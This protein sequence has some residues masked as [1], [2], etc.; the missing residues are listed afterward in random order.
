LTVVPSAGRFHRVLALHL[1]RV[2]RLVLL[3]LADSDAS[4]M[5]ESLE[6]VWQSGA[7]SYLLKEI[8]VPEPKCAFSR[9]VG[10]FYLRG[11]W[12]VVLFLVFIDASN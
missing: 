6:R 5:E 8:F 11:Q 10:R 4:L 9:S 12:T 2:A 1:W 3:S 7:S